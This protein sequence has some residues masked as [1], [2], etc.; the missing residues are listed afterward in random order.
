MKLL[1]SS[2]CTT[3]NWRVELLP[4]LLVNDL[5]LSHPLWFSWS[6]S[7]FL[8]REVRPLVSAN[9]LGS[10]SRNS[11]NW[12]TLNKS[13][14][15]SFT[16]QRKR[17]FMQSEM[18]HLCWTIYDFITVLLSYDVKFLRNI[19]EVFRQISCQIGRGW[20]PTH[21]WKVIFRIGDYK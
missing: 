7:D 6:R 20:R 5:N 11:S 19:T 21:F 10:G 16:C 18:M 14:S 4:R 3:L 15:W 1:F 8:Q 12:T 17:S 9:S 13:S 2:L